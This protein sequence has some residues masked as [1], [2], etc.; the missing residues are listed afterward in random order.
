MATIPDVEQPIFEEEV[1][2]EDESEESYDEED[3]VDVDSIIEN[4]DDLVDGMMSIID[5]TEAGMDE[6]ALELILEDAKTPEEAVRNLLA[7]QNKQ[8][9]EDVDDEIVNKVVEELEEEE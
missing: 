7:L 3:E 4:S 1:V 8:N 2:S 6:G 9:P 5:G